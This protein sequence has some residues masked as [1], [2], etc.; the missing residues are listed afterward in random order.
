MRMNLGTR[1]VGVFGSVQPHIE[2]KHSFG[3]IHFA[4]RSWVQ[5]ILYNRICGIMTIHS[6]NINQPTPARVFP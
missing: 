2:R 4:S 5:P 3:L 1:V 6:K